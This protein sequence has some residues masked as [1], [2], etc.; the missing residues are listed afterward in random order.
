LSSFAPFARLLGGGTLQA[1]LILAATP[2]LALGFRALRLGRR[3]HHRQKQAGDP[4]AY[5]KASPH[6]KMIVRHGNTL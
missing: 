2:A 4:E 5:K 6:S 3:K 1:E